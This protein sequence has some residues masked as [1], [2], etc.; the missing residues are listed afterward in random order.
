MKELSSSSKLGLVVA[1]TAVYRGCVGSV[2][3][4]ADSGSTD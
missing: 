2:Y 1:S 3:M 4:L